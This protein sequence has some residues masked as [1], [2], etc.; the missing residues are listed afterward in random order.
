MKRVSQDSFC[1]DHLDEVL[2]RAAAPRTDET[3][4]VAGELWAA[5]DAGGVLEELELPGIVALAIAAHDAGDDVGVLVRRV[6]A[7]GRALVELGARDGILD[8]RRTEHLRLVAAEAGARAASAYAR[9][10]VDRRE[11]WLSFLCHD[12]K[13]PLNTILNALWL[14]R[15]HRAAGSSERFVDLAERAVRRM[16]AG[17]K[18][19]RELN[20]KERSLPR[21]K[22]DMPAP[23]AAAPS[24]SR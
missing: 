22:A 4:R 7:I 6:L 12:L 23:P 14:I 2:A 8:E 20:Q 16:E 15:E 17:I 9:F 3:T 21:S 13:N 11:A 1:E 18:D 24:T 5:R 19:M 10:G